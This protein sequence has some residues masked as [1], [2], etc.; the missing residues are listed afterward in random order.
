MKLIAKINLKFIFNYLKYNFIKF[1]I[2]N[3][4]N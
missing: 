3:N 2:N 4:I 1:I